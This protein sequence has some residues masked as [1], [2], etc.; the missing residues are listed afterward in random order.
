MCG[1]VVGGGWGFVGVKG[2]DRLDVVGRE[3]EYVATTM[4]VGWITVGGRLV[5]TANLQSTT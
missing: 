4:R 1:G 2:F 3:R 5:Y